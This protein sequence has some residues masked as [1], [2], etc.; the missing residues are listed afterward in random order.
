M[1]MSDEEEERNEEEE[2]EEAAEEAPPAEPEH[3]EEEA[4]EAEEE[5]VKPKHKPRPIEKEPE[6]KEISE[7]EKAM[8][9][10]KKKHDEEEA[11]KLL[12]YEERRRIEKEKEDEELRILKEK[13]EK[14]K[15]EREEEEALMAE[16]KRVEDERRRHEEEERKKKAEEKKAAK[17]AEKKKRLALM[18]GQFAGGE[19]PNFKLPDK[20]AGADLT[21]AKPKAKAEPTLTA[22][23]LDEIKKRTL[24]DLCKPLKTEG[25]D[26]AELRKMVKEFHARIAKLEAERY[27]LERRHAAQEYDYKELQERQKQ[28][29]RQQAIKKGL[30]PDAASSRYPPKMSV[31]S[32][33]D[34]QI[35]RRSYGERRYLYEKPK[36]RKQA[37]VFHGSARPPAEWGK[38]RDLEEL[39]ILRKN[40]EGPR[41]VEIVKVEGARPPMEP[42]PVQPLPAEE[43]E[44]AEPVAVA[45]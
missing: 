40:A 18:A 7:A 12:D 2:E 15:A 9:A 36:V 1:R 14:R 39:E 25:V 22:E 38:K 41:Y 29:A 5:E 32:K 16:R 19:G 43:P 34:R 8:L 3:H 33:F 44:E 37:P 27:D 11:L 10:A 28:Q 21:G 20:P 4:E 6:V 31:A 17:E 23:Q 13:Q 30:D 42:V 45:P 24:A 26:L 35:D